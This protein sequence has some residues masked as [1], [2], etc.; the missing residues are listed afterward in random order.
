MK[1]QS[2]DVDEEFWEKALRCALAIT[3]ANFGYLD[4]SKELQNMSQKRLVDCVT[5]CGLFAERTDCKTH[6][7]KSLPVSGSQRG[8]WEIPVL[9]LRRRFENLKNIW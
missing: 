7:P 8:S 5:P 4:K 2:D 1:A 6:L 3:M 9:L